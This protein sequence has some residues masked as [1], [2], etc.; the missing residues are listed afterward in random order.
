MSGAT[1]ILVSSLVSD[2]AISVSKT[3][4]QHLTSYNWLDH[5]RPTIA[6]PGH[7]AIWSPKPPNTKAKLQP[8]NGYHY[9]DQNASR[10]KSYPLE[11]TF[12]AL[13]ITDPSFSFANLDVVTSRANLRTLLAFCTGR[14][15]KKKFKIAVQRIGGTTLLTKQ[16]TP[17][18]VFVKSSDKCYGE[19]FEKAY[20]KHIAGLEKS[21]GH[22]RVASYGFCGLNL[23]VAFEADAAVLP[24]DGAPE[25]AGTEGVDDLIKLSTLS[26]DDDGFMPVPS[27][28]KK[29]PAPAPTT[30]SS[31]KSKHAPPAKTPANPGTALAS[32]PKFSILRRGTLV[33]NTVVAELKTKSRRAA[34]RLNMNDVYDQLWF[35]DTPHLFVGYHE[36]GVFGDIEHHEASNLKGKDGSGGIDDWEVRLADG[37]RKLGDLLKK[38]C[39]IAE[40]RGTYMLCYDGD[41]AKL[42][43]EVETQGKNWLPKDLMEWIESTSMNEKA[44][45]GK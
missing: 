43:V 29:Q 40:A 39:E 6:V 24:S 8:D 1:E 10:L 18:R 33:P 37:L 45:S 4:F 15:G 7:P 3:N 30:P 14:V 20:T 44:T 42:R 34:H 22:H 38:M 25:A 35:S 26:V 16:S 11:T 19:A 12:R 5:K 9:I 36:D 31:S 13:A 2:P 28:R 32:S 17:N 23:V 21:T 27:R 41:R